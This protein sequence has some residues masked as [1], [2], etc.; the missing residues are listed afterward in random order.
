MNEWRLR[1]SKGWYALMHP[2]CW[3]GLRQG[4]LPTVDH[5]PMFR[6][7]SPDGILDVGANRGQF[8]LACTA[9]LPGVPV[10]SFEPI[11]SEAEIYGKALSRQSHVHLHPFALGDQSGTSRIHLSARRDSSSLL[12]IGPGQTS[13][14]PET[15]EVGTQ[16]ITVKCLDELPEI[17]RPFRNLLLKIDV[18]GFELAVL[19]GASEALGH[20]RYVYCE[21]SEIE[22]YSGQALASDIYQYLSGRGFRSV[23]RLNSTYSK[24]ELVQ[25]DHLFERLPKDHMGQMNGER[26]Q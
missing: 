3:R 20:C 9:F 16:E 6:T 19:K 26:L 25:A 24:G 5:C 18:Q 2:S 13:I 12:P 4:V 14:F 15:G 1:L 21:C 23:M 7:V 17:W 11:P 10:H 22:L 8:A